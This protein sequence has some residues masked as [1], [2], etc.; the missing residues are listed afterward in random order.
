MSKCSAIECIIGS[1]TALRTA[2]SRRQG[3][4]QAALIDKHLLMLLTGPYPSSEGLPS[5][6]GAGDRG[7]RT[8][9]KAVV[10]VARIH[11]N[12]A[13]VQ[14]PEFQHSSIDSASKNRV[15]SSFAVAPFVPLTSPQHNHHFLSTGKPSDPTTSHSLSVPSGT[16]P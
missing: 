8:L 7:T 11:P 3:P 1:V 9:T 10:A 12:W 2:Q 6:A 14:Q 5:N 13:D 16:V 15:A 4:R